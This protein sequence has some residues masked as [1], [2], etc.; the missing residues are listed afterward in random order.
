VPVSDPKL[1]LRA[2]LA[3]R[4]RSL[5]VM[6]TLAPGSHINESKLSVELGVS[7][8]PL[9]EALASLEAERFVR[10]ERDRGFFVTNL[11]T[12]EIRQIYPIGRELD[13]LALR[14]TL[15][16]SDATIEELR[17]LNESFSDAKSDAEKARLIDTRFHRRLIGSCR[18]E[19]LLHIIDSVQAS[20]ER[21]ERIY[22][23]DQRDLTRSAKQHAAII[24]A[25]EADEVEAAAAILAQH[26]NYGY[27][28]L[29]ATFE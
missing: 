9:R 20:M 18:N 2:Q 5:I 19:R 6:Q 17:S 7:R 25:I 12:D 3:R 8:T 13:L 10:S 16:F 26:W 15:H 27:E 29:L 21:Y 4:V 14:S 28:R 11:S 22:M 1:A 24:D 23:G